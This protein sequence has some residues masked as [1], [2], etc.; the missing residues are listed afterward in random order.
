MPNQARHDGPAREAPRRRNAKG[1]GPLRVR[2]HQG[3]DIMRMGISVGG[4]I[5]LLI[6]LWLLFGR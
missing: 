1:G 5:V 3:E 4:L 2:Q 6:I